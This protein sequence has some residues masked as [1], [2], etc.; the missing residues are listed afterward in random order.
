M[1]KTASKIK[2]LLS[3]AIVGIICITPNTASFANINVKGYY[4]SNGTYV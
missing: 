4:R 2:K 3:V 1:I